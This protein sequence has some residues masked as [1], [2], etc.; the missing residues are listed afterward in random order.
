VT[1]AYPIN[2]YTSMRTMQTTEMPRNQ[3]LKMAKSQERMASAKTT[4]SNPKVST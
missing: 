4:L 1:G 2:A 3:Q